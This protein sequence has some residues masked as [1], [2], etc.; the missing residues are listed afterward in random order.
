MTNRTRYF[1]FGSAATLVAGLCTGLVA[2]YTGFPTS[3]LSRSGPDELKFM[4]RTA[5]VVAFANV[6]DVMN[7]ELRRKLKEF[8]PEAKAQGQQQFERETGINIESDIDH[9]VA[10]LTTD[11]AGTPN[12]DGHDKGNGLVVARGRF[13]EVRLAGLARA[14]GATV[15]QYRGKSILL[16][17]GEHAGD[18]SR[19]NDHRPRN[20]SMSFLAPGLVAIGSGELVRHAIDIQSGAQSDSVTSNEE[21][22]KIVDDMDG[23]N[24][25]AVGKFDALSAKANLPPQVA[26]QIPA[27]TW[28]A[29][30]T[31]VNG[32]LTGTLRAEARD[33]ASA[34]NLREVVRGF[35][36]LGKLQAGSNP[37]VQGVL[38][39]LQLGGTGK[40]VS[41]NFSVPA[42]ALEL[43]AA[44]HHPSA[45]SPDGPEL[46]G[47]DLKRWR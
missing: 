9:V 8:E 45:A 17:D 32:G 12:S 25:W 7:S 43:L 34:E 11:L 16:I 30:S 35:L 41:L 22:M 23:G 27:I 10:C 20:M 3:A 44:R 5:T 6:H 13:D 1:I 47:P 36:A 14:H 24:A 33:D 39:T 28:F 19:H 37:D 26:S 29:A 46:K 4:P 18:Q 2:Y 21:M 31:H 42:R 38:Q 40:T 15:E